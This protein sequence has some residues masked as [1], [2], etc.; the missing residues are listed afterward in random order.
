[1]IPE[2]AQR[3]ERFAERVEVHD[4]AESVLPLN[5]CVF[6]IALEKIIGRPSDLFAPLVNVFIWSGTTRVNKESLAARGARGAPHRGPAH[7]VLSCG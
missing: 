3:L 5:A 6:Q 1:L 4:P 7:A 2:H